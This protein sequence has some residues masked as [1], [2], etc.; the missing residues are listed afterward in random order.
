MIVDSPSDKAVTISAPSQVGAGVTDVYP[1][2]D[3][4]GNHYVSVVSFPPAR[5]P[6]PIYVADLRRPV[7]R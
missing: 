7:A 3:A 5:G 1:E 2:I 6:S 4:A